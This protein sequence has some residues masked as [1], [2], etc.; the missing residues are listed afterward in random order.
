MTN[1]EIIESYKQSIWH[2]AHEVPKVAE[3]EFYKYILLE[4]KFD[5]NRY[6]GYYSYTLTYSESWLEVLNRYEN[7]RRWCYVEDLLPYNRRDKELN[8]LNID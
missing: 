6:F 5:N 1:E 4:S 2:P 3:E 8:E 7:V